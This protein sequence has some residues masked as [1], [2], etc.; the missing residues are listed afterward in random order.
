MT[1]NHNHADCLFACAWPNAICRFNKLRSQSLIACSLSCMCV[2]DTRW[3]IFICLGMKWRHLHLISC[4]A[5]TNRLQ[6]T[7]PPNI[8]INLRHYGNLSSANM[9]VHV[10]VQ[11]TCRCYPTNRNLQCGRVVEVVA[12][13]GIHKDVL[14]SSLHPWITSGGATMIRPCVGEPLFLLLLCKEFD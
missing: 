5:S 11:I 9:G 1:A 13:L 3:L 7:P 10:I 14:T 6:C 8:A 2:G 12:H 4:G